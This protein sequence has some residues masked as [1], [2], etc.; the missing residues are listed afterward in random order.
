MDSPADLTKI[1]E[2][3]GA[4][5]TLLSD[6]Q[7]GLLDRFGLRDVGGHPFSEGDIARPANLLLFRTGELRWAHYAGNYRVRMSAERILQAARESLPRE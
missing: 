7:G 3:T 4:K 1:Q 5:F 2:E 6:T